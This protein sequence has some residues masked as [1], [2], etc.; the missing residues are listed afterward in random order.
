MRAFR[1]EN[2]TGH[3]I[4]FSA[5]LEQT[6]AMTEDSWRMR[7]RRG[8]QDE[9]ASFAAIEQQAGRWVG[10][11]SALSHDDDDPVLTGVYVVPEFRRT[12]P[13]IADQLM[14]LVL[15]W[16]TPRAS[17]LR[18]YVYERSEPAIR[19]HQRHRSSPE[20]R[21]RPHTFAPG[22]VLEFARSLGGE[23]A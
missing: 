14:G 11:M 19:F 16:A 10:M 20:G 1:I 18:L 4:S 17:R 8:E 22:D 15:Q 9:A 2:A 6:L 7:G 3:P 12:T 21:A 23:P 5:T 13:R